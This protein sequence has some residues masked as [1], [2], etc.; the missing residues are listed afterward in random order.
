VH[1]ER[2]MRRGSRVIMPHRRDDHVDIIGAGSAWP[3]SQRI[4][5]NARRIED[6]ATW[7][8]PDDRPH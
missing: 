4:V 6:P 5:L 3:S 1:I 7:S 8:G 2:I